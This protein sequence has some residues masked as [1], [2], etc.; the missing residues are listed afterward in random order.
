M[1]INLGTREYVL[2]FNEVS[3]VDIFYEM[4]N[5]ITYNFS[6]PHL[7]DYRRFFQHI[8]EH[9]GIFSTV[10]AGGN[11][12]GNLNDIKKIYESVFVLPFI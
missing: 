9:T 5:V 6:I 1:L 12:N 8:F 4:I 11:W 3:K 2:S 7:D 10:D